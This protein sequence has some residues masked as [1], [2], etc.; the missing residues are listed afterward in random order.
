MPDDP[1][2]PDHPFF[3]LLAVRE[4]IA[5]WLADLTPDQ[6]RDSVMFVIGETCIWGSDVLKRDWKP[7]TDPVQRRL[8]RAGKALMET[9]GG[10]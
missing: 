10:A 4:D 2:L 1:Q 3:R 6:R 9:G 7:K 5:E 8:R